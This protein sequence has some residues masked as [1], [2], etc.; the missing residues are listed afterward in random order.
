VPPEPGG[1]AEKVLF[2]PP[3]PE[4]AEN[5]GGPLRKTSATSSCLAPGS[6]LTVFRNSFPI[7]YLEKSLEEVA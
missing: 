6:F 7:C 4:F 2:L 3:T 5:L 1:E